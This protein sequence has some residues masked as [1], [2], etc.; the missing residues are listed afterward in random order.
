MAVQ[1]LIQVDEQGP[2]HTTRTLL[3]QMWREA[4]LDGMFIPAWSEKQFP[5]TATY[6]ETK[7]DLR[8]ADPFAPVMISNAA[9]QGVELLARYPHKHIGIVLRPCELRS[10]KILVKR[11]ALDLTQTLII[12]SDCLAVF[13]AED[14]DWRLGRAD[15]FDRLSRDALQFAAQ[16]GI[17]PS[18]YQRGCQ[19]CEQ[20][21]PEDVD[22]HIEVLGLETNRHLLIGFRDETISRQLGF[23]D[24]ATEEVPDEILK[25]RARVLEK[26]ANWRGRSLAYAQSHLDES[27]ASIEGLAQ[28]LRSCTSCLQRLEAKCPLFDPEWLGT[29]SLRKLKTDVEWIINCGG[30]GMCAYQCPQGYP[31]FTVLAHLN[32]SISQ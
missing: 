29:R 24:D 20:P 17:L 3:D 19:L 8:K 11:Q 32:H 23:N 2:L 30:C 31:L 26:L 14:F 22:V 25:R 18:R 13:P 4:R 28:H 12:S 27:Q 16:G 1:R 7:N 5:P 6:L 10:F 15:D 21:Y 9:P